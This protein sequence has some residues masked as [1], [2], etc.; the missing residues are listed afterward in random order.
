MARK[1]DGKQ[2]PGN[3][4]H[5]QFWMILHL[6]FFSDIP[7]SGNEWVQI[8]CKTYISHMQHS[9][10]KLSPLTMQKM[11]HDI[12]STFGP[13][14]TIVPLKILINCKKSEG[15]F[16]RVTTKGP[17]GLPSHV[18]SM[19]NKKWCDIL[20]VCLVFPDG[21]FEERVNLRFSLFT[22]SCPE[23]LG[24]EHRPK[25]LNRAAARSFQEV[26]CISHT[27]TWPKRGCSTDSMI[28]LGEGD[29][30]PIKIKS[31]MANPPTHK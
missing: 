19:F 21:A 22:L 27:C 30:N 11:T 3:P 16:Y 4:G 18:I 25:A 28:H 9:F 29:R 23:L 1:K 17:I 12:D 2:T 13:H 5:S 7:H 26:Y 20:I 8:T 14:F 24:R 10:L 31:R 6:N 15:P